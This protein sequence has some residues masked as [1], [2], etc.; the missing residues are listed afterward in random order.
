MF[1]S[2]RDEVS[3]YCVLPAHVWIASWHNY[4]TASVTVDYLVSETISYKS[5][6]QQNQNKL[7]H[8]GT[9]VEGQKIKKKT[10]L[11]DMWVIKLLINT[12]LNNKHQ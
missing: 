8:K 12:V 2:N 11:K 9:A 1:H 7:I 6:S 3:N 10:Y 4:K 5:D